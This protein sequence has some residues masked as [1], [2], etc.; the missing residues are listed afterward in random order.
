M[1]RSNLI[2]AELNTLFIRTLSEL[3]RQSRGTQNFNKDRENTKMEI[4]NIKKNQS[5]MKNSI[6]KIKNTLQGI[7]SGGD[8]AQD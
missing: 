3:K 2:D 7:N 4:E 8:E 6:T 5:E 1:E